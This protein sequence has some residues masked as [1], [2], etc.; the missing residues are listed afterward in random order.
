MK[1]KELFEVD[2]RTEQRRLKAKNPGPYYIMNARQGT[3]KTKSSVRDIIEF[4]AG[5]ST[6]IIAAIRRYGFD[7]TQK[8]FISGYGDTGYGLN[9][10]DVKGY[11]IDTGMGYRGNGE[12]EVENVILVTDNE[13]TSEGNG[14]GMNEKRSFWV[15]K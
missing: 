2:W 9:P 8:V 13:V 7:K 14:I 12:F 3:G 1:S 11:T 5:G 6:T 4:V 15:M 10:G